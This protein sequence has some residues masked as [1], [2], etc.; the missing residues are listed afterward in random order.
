MLSLHRS[1]SYPSTQLHENDRS[2]SIHA[3]PFAHGLDSHSFV[4]D[5]LVD[6][7]VDVDVD[8]L[9]ELDVDVLVDVLLVVDVDVDVD[10]DVNTS[11]QSSPPYPAAQL[12]SYDST[13]VSSHTPPFI[14]GE[15]A[16]SS[17]IS[18]VHDASTPPPVYPDPQ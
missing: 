7:L 16:Q 4:V 11:S 17:F 18:T 8:V 14:H 10:V 5:V 3:A 13:P 9:L 15:S 1:P 12:H 6:V 2:P